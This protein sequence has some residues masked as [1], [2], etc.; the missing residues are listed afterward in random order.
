MLERGHAD[1]GIAVTVEPGTPYGDG[2]VAGY[3]GRYPASDTALAGKADAEGEVSGFVVE[4]AGEHQGAEPLGLADSQDPL[5][6]EW[7]DA[8]VAKE[9]E[10]T[11]QIR[12]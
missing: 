8:A 1:E 2:E 9:E 6:V 5:A 11:C 12:A 7:I 10:G 4:T 3:V